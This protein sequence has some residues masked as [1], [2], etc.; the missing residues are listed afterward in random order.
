L[1]PGLY[2]YLINDANAQLRIYTLNVS[3]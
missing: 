1:I 2:Q 3:K